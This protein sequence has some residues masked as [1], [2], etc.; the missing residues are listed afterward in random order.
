MAGFNNRF[1]LTAD[2]PLTFLHI[3]STIWLPLQALHVRVTSEE[4]IGIRENQRVSVATS[5]PIELRIPMPDA[6]DP[7]TFAHLVELAALELDPEQTEYLFREL[8][9]QIKAINELEAIPLDNDTAITTHGVPYTARTT[10]AMRTDE[11]IPNPHPEDILDQA[12]LTEDG[13]I[14]VPDIPHTELE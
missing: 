10:P 11:W 9:N 13:Y 1:Q 6:I 12:P 7:L 8:N 2:P 3:P 5:A 4:K 14:V